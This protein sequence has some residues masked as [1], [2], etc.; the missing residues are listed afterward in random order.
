LSSARTGRLTDTSKVAPSALFL[1]SHQ[2][3]FN[4]HDGICYGWVLMVVMSYESNH[5]LYDYY[6]FPEEM[7]K[8]KFESKG[9]PAVA[10][11]V[12]ELLKQVC[13]RPL[14]AT[15]WNLMIEWDTYADA[16]ARTRTRPRRIRSIQI[17]VP[18]TLSNPYHRNLHGWNIRSPTI[19]RPRKSTN[20]ITVSSPPPSQLIS[21]PSY[22]YFQGQHLIL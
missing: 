14:S 2:L 21:R 7:Y 22:F 15:D 3:V 13:T 11:R 9:S 12:V 1:L 18:I 17:D 20:P 16:E 6:N 4:G 8:V 10:S 5:L 19:N